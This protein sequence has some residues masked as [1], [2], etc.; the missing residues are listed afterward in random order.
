ML[1]QGKTLDDWTNK[2]FISYIRL[3]CKERGILCDLQEINKD[4]M[5]MGKALKTLKYNNLA[6]IWLKQR[7]DAYLK[8]PELKRIHSLQFI[9]TITAALPKQLKQKTII[10]YKEKTELSQKTKDRL[11]AMKKSII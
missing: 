4:Y 8:T 10:I 11:T 7:I 2:D 5:F 1:I 9:L 3:V 6:K